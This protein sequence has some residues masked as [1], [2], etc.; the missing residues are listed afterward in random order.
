[1][2]ASFW[3]WGDRD[4]CDLRRT[5]PPVPFRDRPKLESAFLFLTLETGYVDFEP[6]IPVCHQGF[7][8]TP[9]TPHGVAAM[10]T[11]HG[12]IPLRSNGRWWVTKAS[13]PGFSRPMAFNMPDG[14]VE[15]RG[16][17]LPARGSRVGLY[18]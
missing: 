12:R 1:M 18:D 9:R 14:V 7:W 10:F 11:N 4:V 5:Q 16:G 3:P 8:P 15:Y 17:G 6:V 2:G 13:T